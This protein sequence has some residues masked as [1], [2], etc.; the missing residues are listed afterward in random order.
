MGGVSATASVAVTDGRSDRGELNAA[1]TAVRARLG[2]VVL[3]FALAAVAWWSTA[4][5]MVG[6]D[7]G[8]G[9]DLGA[10]GWFSGVWVVMMA[11]MMLPSL[12]PTVAL[13]TTMTRRR[14]PGFRTICHGGESRQ[15][16]ASPF[17]WRREQ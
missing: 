2:L 14:G 4:E 7:A 8:P 17:D 13:Y 1:F 9:T 11:A 10:L 12:A 5:R 16:G 3:L 6:M 15:P